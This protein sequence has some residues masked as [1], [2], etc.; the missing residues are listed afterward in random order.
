MYI[1]TFS[2]NSGGKTATMFYYAETYLSDHLPE[3]F[4]KLA[5]R[6]TLMPSVPLLYTAR[7]YYSSP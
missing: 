6:N 2:C 3:Y 1:F 4:L 5:K 7:T